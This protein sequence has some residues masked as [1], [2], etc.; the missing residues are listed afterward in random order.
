MESME[1]DILSYLCKD[2]ACGVTART[3]NYMNDCEDVTLQDYI[4]HPTGQINHV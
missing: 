3:N 2:K 4:N 1:M